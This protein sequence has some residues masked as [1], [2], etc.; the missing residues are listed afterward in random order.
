MKIHIVTGNIFAVLHI[1]F[2]VIQ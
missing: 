2:V 1:L